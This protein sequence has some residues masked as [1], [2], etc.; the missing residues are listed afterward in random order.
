VSIPSYD[1]NLFAEGIQS[2]AYQALSSD[3]AKPLFDRVIAGAYPPGS[4]IKPVIASAALSE[5]VVT[6]HT[7]IESRGGI[8]IG[9]FFFGDW[10]AHGFTDVRHAIAVSSDFT[11]ASNSSKGRNV[12]TI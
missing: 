8:S 3:S 6:E 12:T 4:T 5:G 9:N 1:N 11:D 7:S 2:E 10:K